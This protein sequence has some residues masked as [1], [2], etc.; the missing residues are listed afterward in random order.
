M[1]VI[2]TNVDSLKP[3]ETENTGEK[4]CILVVAPDLALLLKTGD[5]FVLTLFICDLSVTYS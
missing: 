4:L 3:A 2:F 1:F 5:L